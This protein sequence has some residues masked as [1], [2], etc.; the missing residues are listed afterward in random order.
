MFLFKLVKFKYTQTVAR[1]KR[2]LSIGVSIFS[3]KIK[4]AQTDSFPLVSE[5]VAH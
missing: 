3:D 4:S 2:I 5:A 1:V